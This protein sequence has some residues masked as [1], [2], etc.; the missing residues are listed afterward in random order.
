MWFASL[1]QLLSG[2]FMRVVDKCFKY[3]S[4]ELIF[5]FLLTDVVCVFGC[6]CNFYNKN[7]RIYHIIPSMLI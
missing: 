2:Y 1:W 6:V 5:L 3:V 7:G 4:T